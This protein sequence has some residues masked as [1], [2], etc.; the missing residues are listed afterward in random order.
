MFELYRHRDISG[1]SGTGTVAWG[2]QWPDGTASLRWTGPYPAFANWPDIE[3]MLAV[4][5]HEGATEL[6]WLDA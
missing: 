2:V 6:V 1:V 5:G 4:H 3:S